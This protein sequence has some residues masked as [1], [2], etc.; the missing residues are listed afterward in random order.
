MQCFRVGAPFQSRRRNGLGLEF[1]SAVKHWPVFVCELCSVRAVLG[2]ELRTI[3]DAQLMQFER[4]SI[5]DK[6]WYLAENTHRSYQVKLDQIVRFERATGVR[7]LRPTFLVRPAAGPEIPLMWCQEAYSLKASPMKRNEGADLTLSFTT[8]RQFRSALGHYQVMDMAVADPTGAHIN[9][10]KQVLGAPGRS[11]DS[12][13]FSLHAAGL[14]ARLGT[15]TKPSLALQDRHVRW[16][17]ADLNRRYL[18]ATDAKQK[19]ELAKAGLANLALWLL[20]FR[21]K[22]LF[23]TDWED[24]EVRIP[25]HSEEQELV[26]KAGYVKWQLHESKTQRNKAVDTISAFRTLS[27]LSLG[28]WSLRARAYHTSGPIFS[29]PNGKRW[30]SRF[31]R[32]KYLYPSLRAQRALGDTALTPFT[33][34]AG[35]RIEDKFWSLHCY[36]RG[37]RSHVST[38]KQV[39]TLTLARATTTQVYVHGRWSTSRSSEPIDKQ[40][41]QWTDWERLQITLCCH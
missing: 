25:D 30:D 8:V 4:M 19:E 18:A 34:Q 21:S 37:G 11:T 17:D 20:W 13:V 27:G 29:H 33:A 3:R 39:G 41:L 12:L 36:R 14:K 6:A 35:H 7:I 22:E 10:A 28:K 23:N 24:I 2:R 32:Q 38:S 9:Q 15:H 40:Y 16:L 31:F 26:N 5:L 1:P